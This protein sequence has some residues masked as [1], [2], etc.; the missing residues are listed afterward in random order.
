[1]D[2]VIVAGESAVLLVEAFS[3]IEFGPVRNGMR[4][5]SGTGEPRLA[6]PLIRALMRVEAELLVAD[7]DLVSEHEH[8]LRTQPQRAADALVAPCSESIRR[9]EERR[10]SSMVIGM[11]TRKVTITL[12]EEQLARVRAL[13]AAD[14]AQSVSGFVQHAVAVA[15]DDVAGWGAVLAEAL[16][17]TGGPLTPE[18]RAWADDVLGVTKRRRTSAA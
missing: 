8:E 5:V 13:V 15:L 14:K 10:S 18:E 12:P 9:W 2:D 1:M 7:A 17:A 6:A 3:H 11:A 4:R 16:A